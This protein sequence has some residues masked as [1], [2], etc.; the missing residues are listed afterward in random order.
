MMMLEGDIS[1]FQALMTALAA[2]SG[3]G[4]IAG[5]ATAMAMG[6]LGA[7]FWLWVTALIG[8]AT[9]YAEAILAIRYRIMMIVKKWSAVPCIILR[10]G[11]G[12]KW[13]AV[14]F[15]F[16]GGMTSIFYRKPGA[17]QFHCISHR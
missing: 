11:L 13:L 2:T 10:G 16:F 7:L 9:K 12:W 4:N 15:A 1:H 5:V 3:I 17:I 6:G 8:M 14:A